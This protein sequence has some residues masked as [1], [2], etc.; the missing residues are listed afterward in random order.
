MKPAYFYNKQVSEQYKGYF[1]D[2][3]VNTLPDKN[4]GV[5]HIIQN[6]A[7][8]RTWLIVIKNIFALLGFVITSFAIFLYVQG[9]Q[10][11]HT[12]DSSF[13][14]TFG[15]FVQQALVDDITSAMTI[16]MPVNKEVSKKKAIAKM[17]E[18]AKDLKMKLVNSYKL[19]TTFEDKKQTLQFFAF[20]DE[21][22]MQ[23]LFTYNPDFAV[24]MPYQIAIYEDQ[25]GQTWF[26]TTNLNLLMQGSKALPAEIKAATLKIHDNLLK[27][28]VTAANA[29]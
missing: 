5:T 16:K 19:T 3:H 20:F 15:T 24:Y 17:K 10:T 23:P 21:N 18:V 9:Q 8:P 26:A 4:L 27:I 14:K 29:S 6:A 7:C 28:I 25:Q 13:P 22:N 2:F 12:F 1:M 11:L